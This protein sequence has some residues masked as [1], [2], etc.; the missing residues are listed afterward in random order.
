[1]SSCHQPSP[2]QNWWSDSQVGVWTY[3]PTGCWPGGGNPKLPSAGVPLSP[4]LRHSKTWTDWRNQSWEI[5]LGITERPQGR[6]CRETAGEKKAEW[7]VPVIEILV[8]NLSHKGL[9]ESH[10][11][12]FLLTRCWELLS[13]VI[14]AMIV[15]GWVTRQCHSIVL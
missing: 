13:H 6:W 10:I 5:D 3:G 8:T 14:N 1:M 12:F 2:L 15:T 7:K 9:E 4:Q 11:L